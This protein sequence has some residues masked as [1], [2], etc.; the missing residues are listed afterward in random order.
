MTNYIQQKMSY[1]PS[2]YK[3]E[4]DVIESLCCVLGN[5]VDLDLKG[6]IDSSSEY[7]FII[8]EPVAPLRSIYPL[9]LNSKEKY[10][11][12][13]AGCTNKGWSTAVQYL[14][15]CINIT[16]DTVP[17]IKV[18][19]ENIHL[20]EELRDYPPIVDKYATKEL[21][22]LSFKEDLEE[23]TETTATRCNYNTHHDSVRKVYFFDVQWSNCPL[24]VYEEVKQLWR[25]MS[26]GNDDYIYKTKLDDSLFEK[27]P[28]IYLW[29]K[30]EGVQENEEVIIHWW[31]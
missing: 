6:H 9:P 8:T 17:S 23:S 31:W 21:A 20:L 12:R 11:M 16:P 5:G 18:W 22:E 29:L 28:R 24:F 15:D 13:L 7:E 14:I 27:Y 30:H 25:N 1:Y 26:L 3:N 10:H 2:I 4:R 19:K